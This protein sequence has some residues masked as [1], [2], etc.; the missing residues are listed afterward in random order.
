MYVTFNMLVRQFDREKL[1]VAFSHKRTMR[2]SIFVLCVF[3]VLTFLVSA[4]LGRYNIAI[5]DI[6]YAI[7]ERLMGVGKEGSKLKNDVSIVLFNIRFPRLILSVLVGAALAVAGT[8]FQSIFNNPMVSPDVLGASSGA[9]F[10]AALAILLGF[11]KVL[12]IT[13]SFLG[14]VLSIVIILLLHRALRFDSLLSLI[15]TG[16]IC[17]SLFG[18]AISLLKLVADPTNELPAITYW[19]LGSFSG[20]SK[21]DIKIVVLPILISLSIL[22]V[23]RYR[24]NILS[25]GEKTAQSLGLNVKLNRILILL[26]ATLLTSSSVAVSGM[27]S[28]VGL[29]IPH[30][31]KLLFAVDQRYSL[32]A[33]MLLGATFM[34]IVD[35]FAR[36]LSTSEIPLG[37]LTAFVGAPFFM[38][39]I[40]RE[41]R[42]S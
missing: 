40:I 29:V 22:Y 9:G 1:P 8:S 15:L 25:M 34:M 17:S 41:G 14:G 11:P 23:M 10:F 31:A 6:V 21:S 36:L 24:L 13:S 38:F 7:Y 4:S 26:A 12:L 20:A 19:L 42:K 28:W 33:S 39:L 27:I 32:P 16:M 3:F 35:D 30:F 2:L 37:V 18:A 5:K